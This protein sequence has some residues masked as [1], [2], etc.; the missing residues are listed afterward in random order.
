MDPKQST[1]CDHWLPSALAWMFQHFN[2]V[3]DFDKVYKCFLLT[4]SIHVAVEALKQTV[5][6]GETNL[7]I[8]D[9]CFEPGPGSIDGGEDAYP[10]FLCL[11][12][13]TWHRLSGP[14][15]TSLK[16]KSAML[17]EHCYAN[18][19]SLSSSQQRFLLRWADKNLQPSELKTRF[20]R[21]KVRP[22]RTDALL[23]GGWSSVNVPSRQSNDT[24]DPDEFHVKVESPIVETM[25]IIVAPDKF[26]TSLVEEQGHFSMSPSN[27]L[28]V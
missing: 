8:E 6:E 4:P 21:L 14:I 26:S 7:S 15:S 5:I 16:S 9:Q 19:K 1:S 10:Q 20:M 11:V 17:Y 27:S 2:S 22:I 3:S 23:G 18:W 24:N 13:L 12:L 25:E 28:S